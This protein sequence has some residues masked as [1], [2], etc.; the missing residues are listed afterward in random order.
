MLNDLYENLMEED[1]QLQPPSA[2]PKRVLTK[3]L[4]SKNLSQDALSKKSGIAASSI[5]KARE[6]GRFRW[7]RV[8]AVAEALELPTEDLFVRRY[9]MNLCLIKAS[10]STTE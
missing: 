10:W 3:S 9:T 8:E 6:S 4:K 1:I 7:D 2:R 5:R